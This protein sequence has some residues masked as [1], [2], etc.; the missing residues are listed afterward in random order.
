MPRKNFWSG[1]RESIISPRVSDS[2]LSAKIHNL[3]AKL[4]A[5]V[6]WLLG[7]TQTGK[8]SIIRTLTGVSGIEIGN[9]FQ[10]CT[11]TARFYDFPGP[12]QPLIRFLDTRGLSE[13][14]YDPGDDIAWCEQ[15]AHLLIVV[16]KAIDQNGDAVLGALKRIHRAQPRWPIIVAQTTLH[17]LYPERQS[18]HIEPYPYTRR[19]LP[20]DVPADVARALANQRQWFAGFQARFVPIDF[21]LPEDGY[22]P[23]DYGLEALWQAIEGVL[24]LGLH[25]LVQQGEHLQALRDTYAAKAH[26]HITS[27]ALTAGLLG[28]LP[29]PTDV[30]FVLAAQAKMFHSIAVIYRQRLTAQ[31]VTE[32]AGH[33]G[34]SR[35]LNYLGQ[36]GVREPVK[37][38]PG[39]GQSVGAAAA[40]IFTSA[41]TYA[42]GKTLCAYFS[43]MKSGTLLEPSALQKIYETELKTARTL[44]KERFSPRARSAEA[45]GSVG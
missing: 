25:A 32:F 12:E 3:K 5:P 24:P 45:E 10:P 29:P 28:T 43:R 35:G 4:P 20:P 2:E 27:Y 9:G 11:R 41:I 22:G 19:P 18:D 15:H 37:L 40:G 26:A 42:L 34:L 21:T 6:F 14:V 7:K 36:W 17:E 23:S 30:P 8:S 44:F 33:L 1:L 31:T 16:L 13:A 39:L 38:V